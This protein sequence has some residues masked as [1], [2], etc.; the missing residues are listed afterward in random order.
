MLIF[1]CMVSS[2]QYKEKFGIKIALALLAEKSLF[3]QKS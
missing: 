1:P 2:T 3:E